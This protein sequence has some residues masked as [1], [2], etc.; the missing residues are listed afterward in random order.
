M[1]TTRWPAQ[2]PGDDWGRR[3]RLRKY[4]IVDAW[5]EFLASV[6]WQ[7]FVTLTFDPRKQFP[8]SGAAASRE[9]FWWCNQ[10][11]RLVRRP[12]GWI[13]AP[14][15]GGSGQWHAHALIVGGPS[16][17][18]E[19]AGMCTAR[20]GRIDIRQIHDVRGATLYASK[21]AAL[22]GEIVLSDTLPRY[23]DVRAASLVNLFE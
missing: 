14:E 16:T 18:T 11:S 19:A 22:S 2:A 3:H 20:N 23:R 7:F 4:E 5:A 12:L 8:V 15:R 17:L 6:P 10:T 21:Q 9:A 1:L 13:Y